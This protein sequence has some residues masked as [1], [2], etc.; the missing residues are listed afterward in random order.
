MRTTDPAM[1]AFAALGIGGLSR[2]KVRAAVHAFLQGRPEAEPAPFWHALE[3]EVASGAAARSLERIARYAVDWIAVTDPRFPPHLAEIPDPPVGLF[4]RGRVDALS[5]PSIA[6]VGSRRASRSGITFSRSLCADLAK[7]SLVVVSG[8]AHGIDAAAHRGALAGDGTTVAVLGG[9]HA[10]LYPAFHAALADEIVERQGALVSEYAPEAPAFKAQFPERNRL[11]SGLAL[12]V[13]VVEASERSGSLITARCALEQGRDVLAVPGPPGAPQSRGCHRLI[14]QGA[15]LV[16]G[17]DDVLQALG[18]E[19]R[20]VPIAA[21]D[22]NLDAELRSV[23]EVVGYAATTTDEI[24]CA[25]GLEV[26]DVLPRL[27]RLELGGF[28]DAVPGGYIRRPS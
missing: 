28:V 9:G 11:V 3:R 10:R 26:G 2:R 18:R 24:V 16:E 15:A 23:L 13:V 20:T 17:I 19:R 1:L 12:G 4:V 5:E 22:D 21:T 14:K 27:V 8:L 7:E 25:T 6:V